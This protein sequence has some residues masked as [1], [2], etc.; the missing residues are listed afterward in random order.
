[1]KQVPLVLHSQ[2]TAENT[3]SLV[4]ELDFK[5]GWKVQ[6]RRYMAVLLADK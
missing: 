4:K 1:M 2:S 6:M 3:S 5:Y